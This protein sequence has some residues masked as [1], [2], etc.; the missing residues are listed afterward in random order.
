MNKRWLKLAAGWVLGLSLLTAAATELRASPP[1]AVTS[2]LLQTNSTWP[3][4]NVPPYT[5][6][7]T[8]WIE[9]NYLGTI[10]YVATNNGAGT[11]TSVTGGSGGGSGSGDPSGAAAG[12]TNGLAHTPLYEFAVTNNAG[13]VNLAGTFAGSIMT[14][15]NGGIVNSNATTR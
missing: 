8:N 6:T 13:G 5:G 12:A 1:M 7:L 4:L 2:L 11:L 14:T 10:Y 15:N 3:P 9:Y